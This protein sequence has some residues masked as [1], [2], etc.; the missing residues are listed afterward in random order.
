MAF[1]AF[2]HIPL[3]RTQSEGRKQT[4]RELGKCSLAVFPGRREGT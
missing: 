1:D 3:A 4:A 2:A